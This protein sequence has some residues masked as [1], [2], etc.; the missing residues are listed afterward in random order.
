M[1]I[2]HID[3]WIKSGSYI[4]TDGYLCVYVYSKINGEFT[5]YSPYKMRVA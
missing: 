2:G 1:N 3:A 5:E 4:V